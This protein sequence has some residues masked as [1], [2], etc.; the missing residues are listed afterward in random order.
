M[1]VVKNIFKYSKRI[2]D[3]FLVYG[4]DENLVVKSYTDSSFQI[5]KDDSKFLSGVVFYLF[6]WRWCRLEW[7]KVETIV[8]STLDS[9]YIDA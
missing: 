5:D 3:S 6:D 8:A 9:E 2:K 7:F 4:G 1:T